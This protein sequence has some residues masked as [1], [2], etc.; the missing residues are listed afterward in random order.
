MWTQYGHNVEQCLEVQQREHIQNMDPS[1]AQ[2]LK[3]YE[4]NVEQ[5]FKISRTQ[6]HNHNI[7]WLQGEEGTQHYDFF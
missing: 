4:H 5:C 3:Q 7:A 2:S 1:F 6:I